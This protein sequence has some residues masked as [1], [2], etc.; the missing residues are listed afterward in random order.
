MQSIIIYFVEK[1]LNWLSFIIETGKKRAEYNFRKLKIQKKVSEFS[2]Y[3]VAIP[4]VHTQNR[5]VS[6]SMKSL[7]KN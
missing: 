4:L 5:N 6:N 1:H 3:V 7:G 2:F